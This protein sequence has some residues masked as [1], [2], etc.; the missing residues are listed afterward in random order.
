MATK[1]KAKERTLE[2][3]VGELEEAARHERGLV[4]ELKSIP[5]QL[6]AAEREDRIEDSI[7][8]R[9]RGEELPLHIYAATKRK[10]RLIIEKAELELPRW[11][12]EIQA[13]AEETAKHRQA[14]T[15]ANDRANALSGQWEDARRDR[16]RA[17]RSI[18]ERR[19]QLAEW[20]R[21]GPD[22][23]PV[24]KLTGVVQEEQEPRRESPMRIRNI[25]G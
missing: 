7:A 13:L 15:E 24:Q 23:A 4:E 2:V 10:L 3:V 1:T 17:Q 11:N 18:S 19:Q 12:K 20:E 14:A 9:R 8:L 25:N 22:Y 21:R 5:E 16:S 6:A